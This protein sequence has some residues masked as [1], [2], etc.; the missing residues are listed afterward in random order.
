[1]FSLRRK[2]SEPKQSCEELAQTLV[3][4]VMQI[5]EDMAGAVRRRTGQEW[6]GSRPVISEF[7]VYHLFKIDCAAC[8]RLAEPDR[9]LLL[10]TC[11]GGLAACWAGSGYGSLA[12][13]RAAI[14][15]RMGEYSQ[16]AGRYSALG[17]RLDGLVQAVASNVALA[18]MSEAPLQ[19]P[20]VIEVRGNGVSELHAI[21]Q[22]VAAHERDGAGLSVL[23]FL[24]RLFDRGS[25]VMVVRREE[26]VELWAAHVRE[27]ASR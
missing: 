12:D 25:S 21:A 3:A 20:R 1:M 5:A 7:V 16:V 19:K 26:L 15:G 4:T 10:A 13:L 23:V 17:E 2:R 14:A 6:I 8:G 18:R 24:Q 11:E 9:S 27:S 22:C